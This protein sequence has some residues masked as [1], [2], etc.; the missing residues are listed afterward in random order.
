MANFSELNVLGSFLIGVQ[1][2]SEDRIYLLQKD[3]IFQEPGDLRLAI[4]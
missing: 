4:E 3:F 1:R 2:D